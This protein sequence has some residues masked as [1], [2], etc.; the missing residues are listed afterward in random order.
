MHQRRSVLL[1]DDRGLLRLHDEH[2]EGWL[3]LLPDDQQHAGLLRLLTGT[4]CLRAVAT[5]REIGNGGLS[6][7]AWFRFLGGIA[8]Q[9]G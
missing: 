4:E 7:K 9:L 1:R 2:D 6:R 3:H 5:W 8:P